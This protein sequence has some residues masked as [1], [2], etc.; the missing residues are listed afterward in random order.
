MCKMIFTY[1]I[2]HY[3]IHTIYSEK[4]YADKTSCSWRFAYICPIINKIIIK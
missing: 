2:N 4:K 3:S 1:F